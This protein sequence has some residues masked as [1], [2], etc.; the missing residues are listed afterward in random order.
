MAI[1]TC[2]GCFASSQAT[3]LPTLRQI[4]SETATRRALVTRGM[5]VSCVKQ[6]HRVL[7]LNE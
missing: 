6:R 5:V 7:S 2:R 1:A 4:I 3:F